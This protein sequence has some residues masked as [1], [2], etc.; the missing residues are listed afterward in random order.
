MTNGDVVYY[1]DY[2]QTV[3]D[4]KVGQMPIVHQDLIVAVDGHWDEAFVRCSIG[5]LVD[6]RII[7]LSYDEGAADLCEILDMRI[8]QV[9]E[10]LAQLKA[11]LAGVLQWLEKS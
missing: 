8:T 9:E 2:N 4:S 6:K 5:G 3:L 7:R 10:Y 1:V 11:R